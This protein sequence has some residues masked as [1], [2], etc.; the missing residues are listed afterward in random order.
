[1]V[2]RGYDYLVPTLGPSKIPS[3]RF[4]ERNSNRTLCFGERRVAGKKKCVG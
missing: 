1:M 3:S 4:D 2:R